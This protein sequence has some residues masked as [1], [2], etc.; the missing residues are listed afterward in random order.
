MQKTRTLCRFTQLS[1]QHFL[2][3]HQRCLLAFPSPQQRY[4]LARDFLIRDG[5]LSAS[6]LSADLIGAIDVE[7]PLFD[8]HADLCVSLFDPLVHHTRPLSVC[9]SVFDCL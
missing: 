9:L 3:Q 5:Q 6:F 2:P 8:V 7:S 1:L 4:P